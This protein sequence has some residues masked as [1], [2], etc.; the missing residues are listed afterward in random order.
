[1]LR[2]Q[3]VALK[4]MAFLVFFQAFVRSKS[5]M[6]TIRDGYVI[7]GLGQTKLSLQVM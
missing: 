7:T 5:I 6:Q 1:M 4:S 2:I 3:T